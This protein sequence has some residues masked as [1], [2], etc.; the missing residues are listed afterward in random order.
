MKYLFA[1]A[2]LVA[3]LS[4]RPAAA[5]TRRVVEDLQLWAEL[6][7]ELALK[8]GDYLVLAAH[9]QNVPAYNGTSYAD[10]VLGFDA[11]G[12]ALGYEHFWSDQ[13]SGGATVQHASLSGFKYVAPELLLRHRSPLGPLTFGQ[14]LS[15]YRV[16]PVGNIDRTVAA[17]GENYASLRVDLEKLFP[18]GSGP[19]MLRPR[20]SYEAVV[21]MR[22]QKDDFDADERTIQATRLRAEVG[23]RL[24]DRFDFTPWAAYATEYYFTVGQYNP[25]SGTPTAEAGRLNLATPVL[26]LDARFTL[27]QGKEAFERR[28]L[29]TEH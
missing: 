11:R 15:A 4:M 6:Q 5:Q 20:L 28:Q 29:P 18:V 3:S 17:D 23:V 13:W 24:N 2:L 16:V 27:F 10:R 14:R 19:L 26:G 8:N 12:L 22:F 1:C 25:I 7:A 21:H 9:G